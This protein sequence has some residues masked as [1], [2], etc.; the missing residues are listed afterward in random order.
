MS[1]RVRKTKSTKKKNRTA[2][3]LTRSEVERAGTQ[4]VAVG[5]ALARAMRANMTA[6]TIRG[7]QQQAIGLVDLP[8]PSLRPEGA[9]WIEAYRHWRNER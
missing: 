7:G 9:E 5:E 1:K 4:L 3:T 2:I 6:M 8:L